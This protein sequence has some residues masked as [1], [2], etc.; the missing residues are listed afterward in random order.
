[1]I[2]EYVREHKIGTG[3]YGKVVSLRSPVLQLKQYFDFQLC[4]CQ[5]ILVTM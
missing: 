1:M 3:S 4:L 5:G 2:N